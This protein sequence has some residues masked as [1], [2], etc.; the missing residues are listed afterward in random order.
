MAGFDKAPGDGTVRVGRGNF[1]V[2]AGGR[3]PAHGVF[4]QFGSSPAEASVSGAASVI[5]TEGFPVWYQEYEKRAESNSEPAHAMYEGETQKQ[6]I[7]RISS[8]GPGP[9]ETS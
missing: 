4:S 8:Y 2:R 3:M 9:S 7:E 1:L 5:K 6:F